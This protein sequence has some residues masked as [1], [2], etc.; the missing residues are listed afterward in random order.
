MKDEPVIIDI[1]AENR[2]SSFS[3]QRDRKTIT[4]TN[5]EV[6]EATKA[7]LHRMAKDALQYYAKESSTEQTDEK[8]RL[9][10]D[11][12]VRSQIGEITQGI[13]KLAYEG[14]RERLEPFC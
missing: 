13:L 5:G 12:I 10:E 9:L 14:I 8:L 2:P 11:N 7:Q 3:I 4:L 6:Y 1:N